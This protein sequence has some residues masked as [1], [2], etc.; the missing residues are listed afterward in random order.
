M[1]TQGAPE[2][3]TTLIGPRVAPSAQVPFQL[4][5]ERFSKSVTVADKV[6]KLAVVNGT[7]AAVG[8]DHEHLIALPSTGGSEGV[9]T[10]HLPVSAPKEPMAHP[11][12]QL[13]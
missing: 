2:G 9:M 11:P 12:D 5:K 3:Q 13:Q 7:A 1:S 4:L 8:L 6:V 10:Q